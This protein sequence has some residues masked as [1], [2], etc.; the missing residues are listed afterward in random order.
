[1]AE[2]AGRPRSPS[3]A[4][5]TAGRSS[6][7]SS[8]ASTAASPTTSPR[9]SKPASAP[10]LRRCATRGTSL[11]G[12]CVVPSFTNPN[13]LSIVTGA[14]PSVH[15]ICG[16]FF[17]DR[18]TRRG[19]DDERRRATCAQTRSSPRFSRAGAKVAVVTAKD[20]LRTLLGTACAA[21]AFRPRRPTRRR[22]ADNGIDGVLDARRQAAAVG[23]QRRPVRVRVRRRRRADGARPARP[24]VPVDHRL[25][26][27]Q[28]R[29][30]HAGGQR[31]LRDDER[32]PRAARRDGRDDRADRRSRHERQDR[33]RR[34]AADHLPAGL[35][36][37]ASSAPARRA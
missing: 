14:P 4:A 11:L 6:R 32:L 8:S 27:A 23:L 9:R 16:N 33:R 19:S 34:P 17:Y 29:A 36:R 25:R 31:L 22:A 13:N 7:S 24:D 21:S 2:S 1:M 35:V 20:K 12:D 37:R 5:A 28:A 15:G 10:Y 3:T 18:E 26:A 30:R